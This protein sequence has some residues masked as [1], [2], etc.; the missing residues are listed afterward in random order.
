MFCG[1]VVSESREMCHFLFVVVCCFIPPVRTS[2]KN[3]LICLSFNDTDPA[4]AGCAGHL[5]VANG[6]NV[7]LTPVL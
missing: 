5:R 4:E 7:T 3:T 6:A 2:T 1:V